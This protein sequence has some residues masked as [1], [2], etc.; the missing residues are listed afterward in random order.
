VETVFDLGGLIA[1][2]D[3]FGQTWTLD[4]Q[5]GQGGQG[6]VWLAA[7]GRTAVKI[8]GGLRGQEQ[9][10]AV[11]ARLQRVRRLPLDG[12]R[13]AGVQALLAPPRVGYTMQLAGEMF[14]LSNLQDV[15]VDFEDDLGGWYLAT[16]GLARRLRIAARLADSVARLHA[17]AIAYQDLSPG[18]VLVSSFAD[19]DEVLLID[20]DNLAVR[21]SAAEP[22][23]FTPGYG[24][25]EVASGARGASTLAD[26]HALA[27]LIFQTLTTMHPFRGDLVMDGPPQFQEERAD[28]Y[29]VPWIDHPE[30]RSNATDRGIAPRRELLTARL[31]SLCERAFVDGMADPLG[32][33]SAA[34]WTAALYAAADQII[35]CPK[36]GW[37]FR[38]LAAECFFCGRAKDPTWILRYMMSLGRELSDDEDDL[39]LRSAKLPEFTVLGQSGETRI[40][41]RHAAVVPRD[42]E[43][44]VAGMRFEHGSMTVHNY[45]GQNLWIDRGDGAEPWPIGPGSAASTRTGNL[46]NGWELHFGPPGSTHRWAVV[47]QL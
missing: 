12:I 28:R 29:L 14:E 26:A 10:R 46:G 32:R 36:C 8:I 35:V 17:R 20:V 24:A 7:G 31:W 39:G 25:P 5:I 34:E 41:A 47:N 13:I 16:G 9:A 27:V 43:E 2:A 45:S 21:S 15:P 30:D 19:Y 18:N 37:S 38:A 4:R 6:Q 44:P 23:V 1:V 22:V 33:P 3:E 42:P 11:Y 40:L